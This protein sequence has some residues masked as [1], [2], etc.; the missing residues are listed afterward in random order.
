MQSAETRTSE[1]VDGGRG[2]VPRRASQVALE[3]LLIASAI[4]LLTLLTLRVSLAL[5]AAG[6]WWMLPLGLAAGVLLADFSSG[7]VH[8]FGDTFFRED[9]PWLG[10]VL[11]APFRE[12]HRDPEAIT[13]H[14]LLELHGNS[15][16]PVVAV[17]LAFVAA[18]PKLESTT[19]MLLATT[20][21]FFALAAVA[22]NQCHV[23][24][25]RARVPAFVAGLQ[26]RRLIL[27]PESHARHH[28][29]GFTSSYCITT[30]WANPLLDRA[31]FFPHLERRIR[32]LGS[33]RA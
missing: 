5:V 15:C 3:L 30:G 17:L 23:W 22:T 14:G 13:R 8:W 29:G 18:F 26:R 31:G 10:P 28:G 32:A 25:H 1:I 19:S 2:P 11:I 6:A 12:H 9:S 7:V 4:V 33:R 20:F 21:L 27:S 24:A 16:L